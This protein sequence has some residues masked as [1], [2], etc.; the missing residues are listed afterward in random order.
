MIIITEISFGM[1]VGAFYRGFSATA[2]TLFHLFSSH[3]RKERP[4]SVISRGT[5]KRGGYE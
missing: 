1:F 2:Q 3:R 4:I 5:Y